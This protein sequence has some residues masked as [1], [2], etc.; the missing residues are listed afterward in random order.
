MSEKDRYK[1]CYWSGLLFHLTAFIAQ[2]YRHY[3]GETMNRIIILLIWISALFFPAFSYAD[4]ITFAE[5]DDSHI[6]WTGGILQHTTNYGSST[7][8]QTANNGIFDTYGLI[9]FDNIFGSGPDQLSTDATIT[10]AELHLW[11]SRE[12]AAFNN[13][14]NLYQL[15][16]DW[17]EQTVTGTNY[18]GLF[19]NTT[20]TAIDVYNSAVPGGT[21]QELIFDVMDSLLDW[22]SADGVTNFGWGIESQTLHAVNY[23]Y[24]NDSDGDYIPYLIL[25]YETDPV[26]E[27]ATMLLF[28]TGIAGL[29]GS[30]IRKKKK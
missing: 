30:T 15:T 1:A 27:P 12:S 3:T 13:I 10:S 7:E 22:Q 26:P 20:G 9:K 11:M 14:I 18:G 28:G 25:D 4:L 19:S 21:P 17:D 29:V 16:K 6:E 8:I 24:S 5:A 23:F 2:G